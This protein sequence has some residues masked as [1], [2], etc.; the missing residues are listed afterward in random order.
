LKY[1][2]TWLL[3]ETCVGSGLEQ[4]EGN[5]KNEVKLQIIHQF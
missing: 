5:K 1:A 4:I 3:G 2:L